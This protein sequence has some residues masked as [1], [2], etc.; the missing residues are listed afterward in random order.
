M[1]LTDEEL[2][3]LARQEILR[4][5]KLCAER[6]K[7]QGAYGW[8]KARIRP[9]NKNFLRNTL[10]STVADR[11]RVS[12]SAS[13]APGRSS[14]GGCGAEQAASKSRDGKQLGRDANSSSKESA[15]QKAT[16]SGGGRKRTHDGVRKNK[17]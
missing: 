8:Q 9:T 1:P 2:E 7:E 10:L 3:Q 12:G 14:D 16:T 6:A 17:P 4:E 15:P 11:R 5:T 13:K